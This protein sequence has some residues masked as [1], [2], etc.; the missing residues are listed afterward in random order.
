MRSSS[1]LKESQ[2]REFF[3]IFKSPHA[4]KAAPHIKCRKQK[5]TLTTRDGG[6]KNKNKL[7]KMTSNTRD[8][9]LRVNEATELG[10]K[11]IMWRQESL[12]RYSV[13]FLYTFFCLARY[14][15]NFF[16]QFVCLARYC[17]IL[18]YRYFAWPGI[19]TSFLIIGEPGQ[20]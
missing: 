16:I 15:V 7:I 9:V 11:Y 2:S 1:R 6:P 3:S 8:G 17:V 18:L 14:S 13:I 10:C 19:V 5:I 12:A 20:V 4:G